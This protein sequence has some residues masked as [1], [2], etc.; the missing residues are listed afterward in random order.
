ITMPNADGWL[1]PSNDSLINSENSIYNEFNIT[2]LAGADVKL[3]WNNDESGFA[4]PEIVANVYDMSGQNPIIGQSYFNDVLEPMLQ[5]LTLFEDINTTPSYIKSHGFGLVKDFGSIKN[6]KRINSSFRIFIPKILLIASHYYENQP[7][8]SL[9]RYSIYRPKG[10]YIVYDYSIDGKRFFPIPGG[11]INSSLNNVANKFVSSDSGISSWSND[12]Y[13]PINW[14]SDDP[15][16]P[17][18]LGSNSPL[19]VSGDN[20]GVLYRKNVDFRITPA[21]ANPFRVN[22]AQNN[23]ISFKPIYQTLSNYES[24]IVYNHN[25]DSKNLSIYSSNDTVVPARYIRVSAY[26]DFEPMFLDD[27][28][29]YTVSFI[30]GQSSP[31]TTI[32]DL[33]ALL[34]TGSSPIFNNFRTNVGQFNLWD[35][36]RPFSTLFRYEIDGFTNVLQQSYTDHPDQYA[37]L[38]RLEFAEF[39]S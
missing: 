8:T 18:A 15:T 23:D 21:T 37:S 34:S 20:P 22:S 14:V 9:V 26:V 27:F 12:H 13:I 30:N 19:V 4:Q 2:K 11:N 3:P 6:I 5:K 24:V 28:E 25:Q 35:Y 1:P 31:I 17:I 38:F 32:S 7:G 39:S 33:K 36:Q 29:K 16:I 10:V